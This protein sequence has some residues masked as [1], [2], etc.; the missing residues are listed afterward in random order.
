MG[1][2]VGLVPAKAAP[3][4][5]ISIFWSR[6]FLW[7]SIYYAAAV[8][9]FAYVWQTIAPHRWWRWSILGSALILFATYI[10]VE[11][12][13]AI[14]TW[15]GPFYDL[16]QS[17]LTHRGSVTLRQFYGQLLTFATI[18]LMAVTIGVLTNF[19]V[20]HY[21]FRWRTA[22]NDFYMENWSKL[23]L[24]EG[25]A[26]RVQEDTMRFSTTTED[27]GVSLIN[28]VMTLM[29]F[30]PVL[31]VLSTKITALP[32]IGPVPQPLVAAAFLWALSGTL[33]LALIGVKLPGLQFSNQKVEAAYRKE[34][35]YGEDDGQRAQPKTMKK[36]FSEV[37]TNYFR[38]YFNYVYFNVGRILYLQID[39][40]FPYLILGPTIV[41]GFI[42]LGLMT[43]ILNA[44]SQV[45]SSFQ[46]L[47]NSWS[48]I[49]ELMSIYKR[50]RTFEAVGLQGKVERL[51][52]HLLTNAP[53]N[54]PTGPLRH[55]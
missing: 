9:I 29:A 17:A 16:I 24:I 11:V 42:T 52:T 7:F 40:I 10:Q 53:D 45:R 47:V 26:Q 14:N 1:V 36:L 23:R 37:R 54:E 46:Y 6:R 44:F 33:F 20:S 25:A 8:G 39:N 3:Q 15:Y 2:V 21:T 5:G 41:A 22:M 38:L 35:V 34:L 4:V 13:V 55:I 19:F 50:L 28:S 43:Q 18:A 27:L 49:V 48:T 51:T 12:S 32:L 31:V 30:M